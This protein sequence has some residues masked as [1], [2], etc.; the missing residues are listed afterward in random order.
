MDNVHWLLLQGLSTSRCAAVSPHVTDPIVSSPFRQCQTYTVAH[1]QL[2]DL[3]DEPLLP[4][5]QVLAVHMASL[6][7]S[8]SSLDDFFFSFCFLK[9]SSSLFSS[10]LLLFLFLLN[11]VSMCACVYVYVCI[12][13]GMSV[14]L[15]VCVR[16]RSCMCAGMFCVCLH[17][18][19]VC[20]C[21]HV[22]V[23][24]RVQVPQEARAGS[25]GGGVKATCHEH[26]EQSWSSQRA[27]SSL[28]HITSL[29]PLLQ[30]FEKGSHYVAEACFRVIVLL[31]QP[32]KC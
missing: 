28:S 15:S 11:L 22:G 19:C 31:S 16:V 1:L 10:P 25:S 30:F 5:C 20:M 26:W 2:N 3:T 21:M 14:C 6:L 32:L 18:F 27:T 24:T 23:C 4:P 8:Q 13:M 7:R 12:C 29:Q 9:I 17:V